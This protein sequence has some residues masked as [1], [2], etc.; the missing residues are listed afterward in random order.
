MSAIVAG[1]IIIEVAVTISGVRVGIAVQ[2]GK[3]CGGAPKVSHAARLIAIMSSRRKFFM[4]LLYP[5]M[6]GL[7]PR[8]YKIIF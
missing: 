2:T 6:E 5:L 8:S 7:F 4:I 3:G 1:G